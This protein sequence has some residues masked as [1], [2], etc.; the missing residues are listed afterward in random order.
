MGGSLNGGTGNN[1]AVDNS[2]MAAQVQDSG[3]LAKV[4]DTILL[5]T[6]RIFD[7]D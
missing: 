2:Y 7:E 1:G 4:L 6:F 3:I 5:N